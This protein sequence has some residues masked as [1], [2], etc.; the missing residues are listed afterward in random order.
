MSVLDS[1][2]E[3]LGEHF[4]RLVDRPVREAALAEPLSTGFGS[5]AGGEDRGAFL[6]LADLVAVDELG[7][8]RPELIRLEEGEQV[9]G[10]RP[11]PMLLRARADL[12]AFGAPPTPR[13]RYGEIPNRRCSMKLSLIVILTTVLAAAAA[14]ALVSN[15]NTAS[16]SQADQVV[17]QLQRIDA[18]LHSIIRALGRGQTGASLSRQLDDV[19]RKLGSGGYGKV[20]ELLYRISQ[21][22][23]P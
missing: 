7:T 6:R 15:Q 19:N 8:D 11:P 21:N 14:F 13:R 5:L 18:D 16:A 2:V 9:A 17:Q 23:R 4:Q 22:T 10:Q 1:V 3:H 20:D 12:G